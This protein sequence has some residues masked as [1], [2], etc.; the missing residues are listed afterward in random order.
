MGVPSE[1]HSVYRV[2]IVGAEVLLAKML[3]CK[4]NVAI[5]AYSLTLPGHYSIEF[6]NLYERYSF[7]LRPQ[8]AIHWFLG[9]WQAEFEFEPLD[10]C[11]KGDCKTCET[12]NVPGRWTSVPPAKIKDELTIEWA[13]DVQGLLR[14][15]CLP[16]RKK[17][18]DLQCG[19]DFFELAE[20]DA[21][22]LENGRL[23]WHGYDCRIE[24]DWVWD[25]DAC[26][27][28]R[29]FCFMGDSHMRH[30]YDSFIMDFEGASGL[31]ESK[32]ADYLWIGWADDKP[33]DHCTDMLVN[34]GHWPLSYESGDHPW[35]LSKYAEN[36][37]RYTQIMLK[38]RERGANVWWVTSNSAP[39]VWNHH[40]PFPEKRDWRTDPMLELF[41]TVA[42]GIM[43]RAGITVID[44]Y[45]RTSVLN[46]VSYDAAHYRGYVGR[47][48]EV[49]ILDTLCGVN[50][51]KVL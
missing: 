30:N 10:A 12:A 13:K 8:L 3:Y 27:R 43:E 47:A 7:V 6:L 28:D 1:G 4:N 14:N 41:N 34:F 15:M 33:H 22:D 16:L 29:Y 44:T 48:L 21:R 36:L 2:R 11:S 24:P 5:A 32:V 23:Q 26:L 39:T 38:A 40:G 25:R 46:D 31:D 35:D 51:T 49:L 18:Q 19:K 20:A 45:D 50:R 37:E 17:E 42:T 9:I